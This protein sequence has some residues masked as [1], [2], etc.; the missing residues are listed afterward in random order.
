[1]FIYLGINALRSIGGG[2]HPIHRWNEAC[3]MQARV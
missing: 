1:M 2:R 3:K